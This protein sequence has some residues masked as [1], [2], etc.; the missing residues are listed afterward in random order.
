MLSTNDI[1]WIAG[2][3]EGEGCF[4]NGKERSTIVQA[5][6]KEREPLDHIASLLGG[7]IGYNK[8]GFY[9]WY[10]SGS[11]A[12]GVMFTVFL[13]MS[14]RR[15]GQIEKAVK[16]WKARTNHG[17][18]KTKCKNGHEFDMVN[19]QGR[20]MCRQ[21]FRSYD[22]DRKRLLRLSKR[23]GNQCEFLPI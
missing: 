4:T 13:L 23:R 6:Q 20:R 3:L 5:S 12:I 18:Y 22:R 2:F 16:A 21:C 14:S 17:W 7:K 15:K 1:Y 19:G 9:K 8:K 11:R 10:M